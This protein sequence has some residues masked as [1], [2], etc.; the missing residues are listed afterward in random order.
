M[1]P[2]RTHRVLVQTLICGLNSNLPEVVG[3]VSNT[4]GRPLPRLLATVLVQTMVLA[5]SRAR[6]AAAH[7]ASSNDGAPAGRA[8]SSSAKPDGR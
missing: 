1:R 8:P 3:A 5:G 2:V 7:H 4:G 6:R